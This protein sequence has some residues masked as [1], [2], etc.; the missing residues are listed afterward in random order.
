LEA[1]ANAVEEAGAAM[2]KLA[3]D[4]LQAFATPS[5]VY[6]KVEALSKEVTEGAKELKEAIA[7]QTKAASAVEKQTGGIADAKKQLNALRAKVDDQTRK[8]SKMVSILKGKCNSLVKERL[9]PAA[10][11]IRNHAQKK[12][13][14]IEKLFDSLKKDDKIPEKAFSKFLASLEGLSIPA[15]HATLI[16]QKLE[17]DGISKDVF[18]KYVVLYF[19]VVKG[20]AFTDGKDV[21][22]CKTLRKGEE[23]EVVEV[24]EGPI[25]DEGS[26]MTRIRAKSTLADATEGWLTVAGSKG[27]SFLEKTTKPVAKPAAKP[28]ET[29]P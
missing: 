27:T 2:V 14:T 19:K 15:E 24:L 25:L 26:Q 12:N 4:D 29:K 22:K 5:S 16:T 21:S 6:Q 1:K 8:S 7:E 13:L 9:E 17:A 10:E 3:G 11:G 18:M 28:A 20:I 23:G